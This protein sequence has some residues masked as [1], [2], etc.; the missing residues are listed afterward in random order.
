MF[1]NSVRRQ[2]A[3]ATRSS[4]RRASTSSST[5]SSSSSS[6]P[7]WR[8]VR[9]TAGATALAATSYYLGALYP[10][11]FA[12]LLSP[13][14][15][16]PPLCPDDPAA[17]AHVAALE[18]ELHKL[19]VL[20]AHRAQTGEDDWYEARPYLNI[21]EERRVNSLTAGTLKGPGK[22]AVAPLVRARHD[23]RENWIFIHVGRALCGHEGVIHGGLL[24]TLLDESLARV[25]LLN[26]P[27]KVGVTANLTINYKAPTRADQFIV[28]KVRLIEA[29][30]RK[31][32]VEGTV[33]DMSGNVLV[34]SNAL[35]VQPRYAKLLNSTAVRSMLGEPP[36]TKKE[37]SPEGTP[38]PVHLPG[39]A[40]TL[41][42]NDS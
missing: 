26:L 5:A 40:Q 30:G 11:E 20:L 37:I 7:L 1:A 17:L 13:R 34:E 15:A 32:R 12:H 3:A 2:L 21:P 39:G 31:S 28:I 18:E 16:P 10:P 33:E 27:E 6:S 23:A 4:A 29:Q 38:Q 24:A 14:S 35:F 25:A 41:V 36:K 19:P 8:R 22:L 42:K 9:L